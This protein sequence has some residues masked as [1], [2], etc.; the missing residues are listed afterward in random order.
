MLCAFRRRFPRSEV[1]GT[2][3]SHDAIHACRARHSLQ[4]RQAD[5]NALAAGELPGPFDLITMTHVLEHN[6][7]P[8]LA[9]S[10]AAERLAE[11]GRLYVEV[12]DLGSPHWRGGDFFH[13][14]HLWYFDE[15]SLRDVLSRAGLE[16]VEVF[17]GLAEVW[18]W[19]IGILARRRG[20]GPAAETVPGVS[21][22]ELAETIERVRRQAGLGP[23][24]PAV[25]GGGHAGAIGRRAG[26][27]LTTARS[28]VLI[29]TVRR[30]SRLALGQDVVGVA[31]QVARLRRE[32][33]DLRALVRLQSDDIGR[34]YQA[35]NDPVARR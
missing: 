14:A 11:D 20:L 32:I 19:G 33:D 21:A 17:R 7:H 2:D 15:S 28:R 30:A 5:W 16:P 8:V 23:D 27:F 4:A 35:Q 31:R 25:A 6:L 18:P 3:L 10:K 12:P 9:L 1:V 29:P 22:A 13:I 24:R 34:L 26:A